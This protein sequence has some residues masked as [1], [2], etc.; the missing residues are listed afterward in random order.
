VFVGNSFGFLFSVNG[1]RRAGIVV[2]FLVNDG[3]GRKKSLCVACG[4]CMCL[5]CL[6]LS[7]CVARLCVSVCVCV[8]VSV[9]CVCVVVE[10][11]L[12]LKKKNDGGGKLHL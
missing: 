10:Y 4:V 5:R 7:V 11:L 12:D 9:A 3:M 2:R 1:P 8:C 6:C